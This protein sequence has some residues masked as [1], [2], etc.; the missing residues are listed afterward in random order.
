MLKKQD[1]TCLVRLAKTAATNPQTSLAEL[2]LLVSL[3]VSCGLGG[4][5]HCVVP[6][7]QRVALEVT[8]VEEE[9]AGGSPAGSSTL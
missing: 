3:K 9:R 5:L 7:S 4:A 1:S 6:A 2:S 8:V